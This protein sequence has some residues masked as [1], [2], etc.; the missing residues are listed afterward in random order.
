MARHRAADAPAVNDFAHAPDSRCRAAPCRACPSAWS[1]TGWSPRRDMLE[2]IA[3][4]KERRVAVVSYLVEHNL[5]DAR[6][7]AISA[8]QEFGVPL[9]D[10]DAIQ[11]DLEIGPAGQREDP[12]QAPRAAAG[13]ARQ[14][15]VRRGLGSDEPA[16]AGRGQVRDRLLRRSDRRRGGQAR[17]SSSPRRSSRSTRP[18]PSS[19]Q[20]DFEMDSLEVTAGDDGR[21]RATS[22]RAPTSTTRPS[23]ASSTR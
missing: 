1:R 4:A 10:L 9:L 5:A 17:R 20:D 23:S 13:Q 2:A 3:T 18:C 11:P 14:A 8:A 6:E 22:A 19:A 7:I 15:A 16:L 21:Q 12:A